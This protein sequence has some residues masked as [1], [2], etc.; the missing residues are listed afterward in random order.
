[1]Y[2]FNQ[3][4]DLSFTINQRFSNKWLSRLNHCNVFI[5]VSHLL[6]PHRIPTCNQINN[7]IVHRSLNGWIK[8]T[9]SKDQ[10]K[11]PWLATVNMAEK[12][13]KWSVTNIIINIKKYLRVANTYL[14]RSTNQLEKII[15][16]VKDSSPDRSFY[17]K[18][19]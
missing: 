2:I 16:I 14:S 10:L 3:K 13:S 19:W 5:I 6:N 8:P 15:M 12:Y 4:T 11:N 9:T 1:M 7:L 17:Q 18:H